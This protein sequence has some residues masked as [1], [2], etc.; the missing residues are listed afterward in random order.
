MRNEAMRAGEPE[1]F[2]IGTIREVEVEVVGAFRATRTAGMA[3]LAFLGLQRPGAPPIEVDD[4][5]V[6]ALEE[7]QQQQQQQRPACSH[8]TLGTGEV[9]RAGHEQPL[10]AGSRTTTP[11]RRP[12]TQFQGAT[13]T[14]TPSVGRPRPS[15]GGVGLPRVSSEQRLA[16][17]LS[18]P[19]LRSRSLVVLSAPVNLP[20]LRSTALTPRYLSP[21]AS[22]ARV[23]CLALSDRSNLLA[24][25]NP[26]ARPDLF[27]TP[28]GRPMALPLSAGAALPR[29]M[30]G[31]A[32]CKMPSA[33]SYSGEY[34]AATLLH[35]PKLSHRAHRPHR[36]LRWAPSSFVHHDAV[37]LVFGEGPSLHFLL[38]FSGQWDSSSRRQ[39][40]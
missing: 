9:S 31:M 10:E 4:A 32:P 24:E 34:D 33:Q 5:A 39:R 25:P 6:R 22:D 21:V 3:P 12:Q 37:P 29:Y 35:M 17:T 27:Q 18:L 20:F 30:G 1:E 15:V 19:L 23:V 40:P 14:A 26:E 38:R 8:A 7:Q 28:R 2:D 16:T 13:A 36:Q 11:G